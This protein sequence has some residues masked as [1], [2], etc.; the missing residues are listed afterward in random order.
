MF[1]IDQFYKITVPA[2]DGV[3]GSGIA[4]FYALAAIHSLCRL[5]AHVATRFDQG[6]RNKIEFECFHTREASS[7]RQQKREFCR[8]GRRRLE[9]LKMSHRRTSHLIARATQWLAES[10]KQ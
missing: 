2:F 3:V 9:L 6:E 4:L 8:P 10:Q 5:P 1:C 7:R